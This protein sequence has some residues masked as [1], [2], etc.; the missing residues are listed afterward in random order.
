MR[1][2]VFT[3]TL[4]LLLLP[5]CGSG[6]PDSGPPVG[7]VAP[8]FS[9]TALDGTPFRLSGLPGK[10]VVL[11]FWATWC[12]PCRAMI[13]HERQIVQRFSLQPFAFVGISA[14]SDEAELRD[15]VRAQRMAWTHLLDGPSGPIGTAY[16]VE[17]LPTVY[18]LDANGVI[19]YR[20]V[21]DRDLER[22]VEKLLA[23][24]RP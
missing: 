8:D 2:A 18:V 4:G 9:G 19:R 22:A 21:R 20:D 11:D 12:G 15:F 3:V 13:P 10:V 6:P 5:A 16:E 17:G 24:V 1:R 14:D 7:S 23:E